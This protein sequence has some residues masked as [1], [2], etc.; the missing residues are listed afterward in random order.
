MTI[1]K[2]LGPNGEA[3]HVG[4]MY[5][6]TGCGLSELRSRGGK[7]NCCRDARW[8]PPTPPATA[9]AEG[10]KSPLTSSAAAVPTYKAP[11]R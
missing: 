7:H 4:Q 9:S 6:C 8:L 5:H 10:V 11:P 3:I 2:V 1:F